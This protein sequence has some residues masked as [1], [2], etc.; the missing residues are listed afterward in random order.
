MVKPLTAILILAAVTGLAGA[1]FAAEDAAEGEK[2]FK[3]CAACHS[4]GEGAKNKIGPML[5]GILGAKAASV[6]DFKYSEALS[7][8]GAAGLT[9][10]EDTLAA[11]LEKPK[12]YVPGTTM[13]NF[14]GLRKEDE[15]EAV[16]AYLK[17][18]R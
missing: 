10:S 17:T 1:A 11:Y 6:P 12:D 16:I 4:V 14:P 3:K 8:K 9:W 18:F 7:A 13:S 5:N 2:V 15:R